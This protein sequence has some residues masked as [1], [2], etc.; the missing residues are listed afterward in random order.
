MSKISPQGNHPRVL[1]LDLYRFFCI[2]IITVSFHFIGYTGMAEAISSK[3]SVNYFLIKILEALKPCGI[4]GFIILSSYFLVNETNSLKKIVRFEFL[5][6]F[7]SIA[8]SGAALVLKPNLSSALLLKSVFPFLTGHYWYPVNYIILLVFVPFLNRFIFALSQ[9]QFALFVGFLLVITGLFFG[10]N[11]FYDSSIYVG[12]E[13]RSILWF[14]TLYICTAYYKLYGINKELPL[15]FLAFSL[16]FLLQF[17]GSVAADFFGQQVSSLIE[18]TELFRNNSL[19]SLIMAFASFIIFK[20]INIPATFA[21]KKIFGFLTPTAFV[22]YLIQ[23]NNFVRPFLWEA[24]HLEQYANSLYLF[25]V[26]LAVFFAL[27]VLA[28]G[29]HG[30]YL[31]CRKLF[32]FKIENAVIEKVQSLYNKIK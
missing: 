20:H 8:I 16:C 32:L 31:I 23:E 15:A 2:F 22:I 4:N 25:P 1:N 11:I 27:L 14:I 7:F 3:T 6:L 17:G 5:L 24:L 12:H 19:I 10:I 30:L 28:M 13:T 26:M 29:F 21:L 18:F 9:R